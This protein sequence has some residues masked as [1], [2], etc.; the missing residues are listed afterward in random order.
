MKKIIISS[1]LALLVLPVFS[2]NNPAVSA[3]AMNQD[4]TPWD[5]YGS[6][7]IEISKV[8]QAAAQNFN[9]Q[10]ANRS[11][12][13][14]YSYE[15]GYMAV[16]SGNNA[17]NNTSYEGVLYDPSGKMIGTVKRVNP[18][19][20]PPDVSENMKKMALNPSTPFVYV[21]T[22]SNG[23]VTYATNPGGLWSE[24]DQNGKPVEK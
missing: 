13:A 20:L 2:Q 4:Q 3:P 7:S 18:S 1:L 24:F 12:V 22:S 6:K 14:W 8:P 21:I 19:T 11:N 17:A 16:Y 9:Q 10:Y 5:L 15:K 23:R